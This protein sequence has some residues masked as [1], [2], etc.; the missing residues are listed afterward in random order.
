M[1]SAKFNW[2]GYLYIRATKLEE[3][4]PNNI[5]RYDGQNLTLSES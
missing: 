5:W 2:F 1:N 3:S 4:D